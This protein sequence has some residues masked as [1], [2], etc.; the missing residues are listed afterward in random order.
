MN[1]MG[2]SITVIYGKEP[3][4]DGP[5]RPIRWHISTGSW[6]LVT[7][8][9]H[10][11]SRHWRKRIISSC[12][13]LPMFPSTETRILLSLSVSRSNI[14]VYYYREISSSLYSPTSCFLVFFP[15]FPSHFYILSNLVYPSLEYDIFL[16][17]ENAPCPKTT[18]QFTKHYFKYYLNYIIQPF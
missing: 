11:I 5:V 7:L 18:R 13:Q 3:E 12:Y 9:D 8:A 6:Q 4:E 15:I 10:F 2:F 17:S 14:W 16:F 1:P